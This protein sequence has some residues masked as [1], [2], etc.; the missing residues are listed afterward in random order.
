V[1]KSSGEK[2]QKRQLNAEEV[3]IRDKQ[4]TGKAKTNKKTNKRPNST[5]KKTPQKK[6]HKQTRSRMRSDCETREK[7]K[8]KK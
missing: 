4:K 8:G 3:L 5:N 2:E 1:R 7:N 6:T